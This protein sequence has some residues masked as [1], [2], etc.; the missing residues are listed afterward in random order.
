MSIPPL[1]T[2]FIGMASPTSPTGSITQKCRGRNPDAST[3]LESYEKL[4][5]T[6][7][8][9]EDRRPT[10]DFNVNKAV[11]VFESY[12]DQPHSA[13]PAPRIKLQ[14]HQY[15][16]LVREL[17]NS[18][19][20]Q[21]I[22]AIVRFDYDPDAGILD[23]RMPTP[24]HELVSTSLVNEITEQL[25]GIVEKGGRAGEFAAQ[26]VNAGSS[27]ILLPGIAKDNTPLRREPDAQFQNRNAV[28]PGLVVEISYSQDRKNLD[29]MAWQYIQGSNG[30][31]K[32]VIGIDI[33]YGAKASTVSLWRPCYYREE[34]DELETL[35]VRREVKD[36]LFRSSD[37][38]PENQTANLQLTLGDFAPDEFCEGMESVTLLIPYMRLA[39]FVDQAEQ[40]QRVR[41]QQTGVGVQWNR[42]L[43]KRP[44]SSADELDSGD[45][46][47]FCQD[48]DRAIKKASAGDNDFQPGKKP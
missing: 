33:G 38:T 39:E 11:A 17:K 18:P 31:I 21:Y 12:W 46:A 41:E 5:L 28:Y 2:K 23:I 42:I 20:L 8:E 22:N 37:G 19:S 34:G 43:K 29:K 35:D 9:T 6:P 14:P 26:I 1:S 44:S 7:P 30:N 13:G 32:A 40:L 3:P 27:R 4:P 16:L 24:V 10:L 36:E 25:R 45:E 15:Q 48:E 47:R